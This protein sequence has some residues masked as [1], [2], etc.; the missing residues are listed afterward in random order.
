MNSKFT[1]QQYKKTRKIGKY[2]RGSL[3][4]YDGLITDENQ[5]FTKRLLVSTR[6]FVFNYSADVAEKSEDRDVTFAP[7]VVAHGWAQKR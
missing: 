5:G 7:E 4:K 1:S 3:L 6:L 2:A